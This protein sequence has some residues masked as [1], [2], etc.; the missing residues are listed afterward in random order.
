MLFPGWVAT[1]VQVPLPPVVNCQPS[2]VLETVHVEDVRE[3]KVTASVEVAEAE[4]AVVD[5]PA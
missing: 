4:I 1:I 5:E 3:A 2:T